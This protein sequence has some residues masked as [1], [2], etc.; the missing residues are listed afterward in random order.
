[1]GV[2]WIGGG[3]G[4]GGGEGGGGG[5]G[6]GGGWGGG[7]GGGV[8][9]LLGLELGLVEMFGGVCRATAALSLLSWIKTW[10]EKKKEMK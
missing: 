4:F 10:L 6:G 5:V 8:E 7:G 3:V 9:L 2:G 1:L